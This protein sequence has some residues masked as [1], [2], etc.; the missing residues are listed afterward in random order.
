[1]NYA[2]VLKDKE[3]NVYYLETIIKITTGEEYKTGRIIDGKE[4]Y[5]KR[6]SPITLRNSAGNVVISTGLGNINFIK[7]EGS[8]IKKDGSESSNLP[9]ID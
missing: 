2:G 9:K 3:G 4:E 7:L 6:F 1:M 5:A 8:I